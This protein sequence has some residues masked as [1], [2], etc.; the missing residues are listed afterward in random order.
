MGDVAALPFEDAWFDGYWSL[1][2]IEH[3]RGGYEPVL[4]EMRR[5]I[6]V[7]GYLFLTFPQM[8]WL[9][10]M[11]A[12]LG[13]YPLF[14]GERQEDGGFYQYALPVRE[15]VRAFEANGFRLVE[16]RSRSRLKGLKDECSAMK[17]LLQRLYSGSSRLAGLAR[18]ALERLLPDAFGHSMLLVF[19]REGDAS[20]D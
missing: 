13:F 1:G 2:V 17:P 7:G 6:R 11:K 15:V 19:R 14:Q 20:L 10:R 5:V 16:G 18:L 3:F 8:S 4:R 12:R 9:R